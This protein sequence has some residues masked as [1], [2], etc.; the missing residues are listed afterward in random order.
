MTPLPFRMPFHLFDLPQE[1]QD[2]IYCH[3]YVETYDIDAHLEYSGTTPHRR[4]HRHPKSS[5][6][7][8]LYGLPSCNLELACKKTCRDSK[9][10]RR[11][12][13]SGRL[14]ILYDNEF[15]FKC[16]RVLLSFD[17]KGFSWLRRCVSEIEFSGFNDDYTQKTASWGE[18]NAPWDLIGRT[19]S[20]VRRINVTYVSERSIY[21]SRHS[22]RLA[23][24]WEQ[25]TSANYN[26]HFAAGD[27]DANFTFP[28]RLLQLGQ[29]FDR[30][31]LL[32]DCK[33][34][35]TTTVRWMETSSSCLREQV[36]LRASLC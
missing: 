9:A 15:G 2:Y 36:S 6:R 33:A 31:L 29:L 4:F 35:L 30:E 26:E 20:N 22:N 11:Q 3:L 17:N 1:L 13:F 7:L 28:S 18:V 34:Y 27:K 25:L 21:D 19:C 23:Q 8:V 5:R 24:G 16:F 10:I 32:A 12:A 14:R